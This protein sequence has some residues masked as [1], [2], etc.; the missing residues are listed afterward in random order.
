MEKFEAVDPKTYS[1]FGTKIE[2]LQPDSTAEEGWFIDNETGDR[3]YEL[4]QAPRTQVLVARML[5]GILPVSDLIT[6]EDPDSGL[7]RVFSKEMNLDAAP[8]E[9]VEHPPH[10]ADTIFLKMVFRDADHGPGH[11][12]NI[13]E[14]FRKHFFYD[15]GESEQVFGEEH[16]LVDESAWRAEIQQASLEVQVRLRELLQNFL[17]QLDSEEGVKFVEAILKSIPAEDAMYSGEKEDFLNDELYDAVT[18]RDYFVNR[19]HIY[20]QILERYAKY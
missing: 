2:H 18:I 17:V 3:Y 6:L 12:M 9:T 19:A 7:M 11:N 4:S 8:E 16:Y 20:L 15:F 1:T 5:K 14:N 10:V 13:S